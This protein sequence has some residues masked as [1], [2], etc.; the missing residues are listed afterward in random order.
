MDKRFVGLFALACVL[1][2]GGGLFYWFAYR[3]HA[4][5]QEC[6]AVSLGMTFDSLKE[7]NLVKGRTADYFRKRINLNRIASLS[8]EEQDD[9]LFLIMRQKESYQICL[10]LNGFKE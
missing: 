4:V 2:V 5:R 10:Q 9:A 8:R 6:L 1:I 7:R 3:P